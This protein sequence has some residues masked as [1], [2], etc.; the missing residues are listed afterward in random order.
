GSLVEYRY[1]AA[2]QAEYQIEYP[3]YY[4]DVSAMAPT[5]TVSE[6]T[7]ASAVAGLPDRSWTKLTYNAYDARGQMVSSTHYGI[8]TGTGAASTAEGYG[9]TVYAYDQAGQLISR[10]DEGRNAETFAYDGMGRMIASTDLNGGTTSIAFNDAATQTVVTLANGFVQTS[11]YNKAGELVSRTE[12]G[13]YVAGGTSTHKYD[14]LGRVRMTTDAT[15]FNTYH[16]YDKAGR[17]VADINHNGSLTEYRYDA[18][19][20]LIAT[21]R[22]ANGVNSAYFAQLADPNNPIELSSIRPSFH[23]FD[24][25][26]WSFYDKQGRV[27]ATADGSGAVQSLQYDRSG[28][29]VKTVSH[30]NK[31][32]AWQISGFKTDTPLT[33]A[34][35]AADSRDSIARNFYDKE[36]R[37][38]A[39]LDGE[40]FLRRTLYDKAGQAVEEIAYLNATNAAYRASGTLN[41]LIATQPSDANDRRTRYVYDGRGFLRFQVD[42]LNQVTEYKGDTAGQVTSTIRYAGSIA[43]TSDY[44]YDNIRNLVAA[45]GLASSAATRRSWA[46]YDSAGRL[47]F[48]INPEDAVTR[49][50]YDNMGQVTKTVEYAAKRT[51]TTS[52]PSLATMNAWAGSNDGNAAN[53]ITRNYYTARG[54][55]RFTVDAEGYVSRTD[56][57]AEGR[58]TRELRWDTPL[59]GVHDGWTIDTVYT[60]TTG[61]FSDTRYGYSFGGQ[62]T[63][64]WN[65]ENNWTRYDYYGTGQLAYRTVVESD[66]SSTYYHYDGAGRVI[67]EYAAQGTAEQA[68]TLYSYDGHGNLVSVTDPRGN[69]TTRSY[70]KLGQMLTETTA[71]GTVSYQYNAFGEAVKA[72][73]ARGHSS[74]SYYDRLGRLTAH[75]DAE[76][77][78]TER[79]YNVFGDLT[80]TTRRYNRA[81]NAAS[82]AAAPTYAAH[83]QDATTTFEYDRLGR[84]TKT[85]DAMGFYEQYTLDAHGNRVSVRNKIGGVV[86]NAFDRRGLLVAETLPMASH[87]NL[88]NVVAWSV[89]NRF[90]YDARGNRTKKI[91]ADGLAEKRTTTYVYD[92]AD[93]LVETRGDSVA[94]LS[95]SDHSS[96]SSVVPTEKHKYD[97]RGR[98]IETTG[99]LGGRTLYYYDK[100]NRKTV[101]IAANGA[102]TAY[103]YDKNGNVL[104]R[105]TYGTAAALPGTAGGS[106]PAAPGGEYRETS[107]TY[108]ALN[109]L[110]TTTVAN[111]RTGAWNGSNYATAIGSVTTSFDYDANGNLIKT[112]DGNGGTTFS[113][114]DRANRRIASVDAENYLSFWTLDGEGNATQEERYATRLGFAVSTGHDAAWLRS[115]VAGNSADRIT[116]FGYDKNGR[117]TSEWRL[118]IWS[119]NVG[120]TGALGTDGVHGGIQYNYNGLGQVWQKTF[121][122]GDYISFT[123]DSMGRLTQESRSPF[124]D[125]AGASVR[126]TTFYYYNGVNNLTLSRQ[127]GA[128]QGG[129]DRLTRYTYGAGGRMT[130]MTDAAGN[131]YNYFR[132]AAGNVLRES[133]NRTKSDGSSVTEG[134]LYNRDIFGRATSQALA[135]WNGSWAKGDRQDTEY[136][137][138]G[139]ISRRGVNGGWQEQFAYDGAGRMW[140]SNSG[141]GVWRFF[142][143]DANGNQTLA[144]ES[145]GLNLANYTLDQALS[146]A[147]AG[148]A[149]HVGGAYIDGI[150]ATINVFDK[151]GQAV[152]T[153]MPQRQLN[154]TSAA[155]G[156][157]VSRTYTAFG[158]VASETDAR[159]YTTDYL[160][161]TMGRLIEKRSPAVNYTTETGA[162]GSARPTEYYY[163]DRAGRLIGSRDAN[164]NLTTR[165][166]LAGTGHDGS[167]A[168]LTYEY[169]S[170]GGFLR[171]DYDVFGDKRVSWDEISRRTDMSYDAMGRLVQ[172]TRANGLIDYYAYDL[173]GQRTQHWNN[174]LQTPVYGAP[175]QVWVEDP[176]YWDPYYGYVYPGTGHW[177]THTPIVGYAPDKELTDY[178]LQGRVVRQVA[179]GGD[180]TT[181]SYAWNG[182]IAT[183]GMG[184]F[185]GWT[186]TTTMAN[187]RS[188]TEQSDLFGRQVY[189]SDLGS[190]VYTF[191]YNLA[192]RLTQRSG[193]ETVTY[194]WLNSGKVA[195]AFSMTGSYGGD[196]TRKGTTYGYDASGNLTSERFTEEGQQTTYWWNPYDYAYEQNVNSWSRTYK[197]ATAS[198]DG[199]NRIV[200]WAEVGGANMA[201]ANSAYEYDLVGNI[202]RSNSTYKALDH[203]GAQAAYSYAQDNWYRYDSMN[204]L[205]TKGSLSGGQIVRSYGGVDYLYDKAGQRVSSSRTT[206]AQAYVYNPYYDP[207]DYYYGGYG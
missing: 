173:L 7:L 60:Y 94:V 129:G 11:T 22:Y 189:K 165:A 97:Q 67:A 175:E 52:L 185:G 147:T 138:Y 163:Y 131:T 54:E 110:K 91:E 86:T 16:L 140:R 46:V 25:C 108:D 152:Q 207:Y 146:A 194:T 154:D 123:Y 98:L 127:G 197:N 74:Y 177:E 82:V 196:Y 53:R 142:V 37:L 149:Y 133:Y 190:H 167:E 71:A 136:N 164:G 89:T 33:L 3:E 159:G 117:R 176:P 106:A 103:T 121:G 113:F 161:N 27:I 61:T 102:Y 63:D 160:Y 20:R 119:N 201:S 83:A 17:Q 128:T 145:E 15:G 90:E 120:S 171:N 101:E 179:F 8:A 80:G 12:S 193:G 130:A 10:M 158:E 192:G 70:D 166:L 30:F 95:Q 19:N 6:A 199:L 39:V 134:L 203:Q 93:R 186:E 47:A 191:S 92:K 187:G 72:T 42:G 9:R 49:F 137:V 172:Q 55:L 29:L 135:T 56:F 118:Y 122:N 100:L 5:A 69:V 139:D 200:S 73:N 170:D 182:A 76:D 141:D 78:V 184:T 183:T 169:H 23:A 41:Q 34:L 150:N 21:M 64:V 144:I 181:T 45:S 59:A 143:H 57:D 126:P 116:Q 84:I 151:R 205:V 155:T 38:L 132:D 124:T 85:T 24:V 157:N 28:R 178:D 99:A 66:P 50:T 96:S 156:F 14:K 180:V 36:G 162:V 77:Y 43:A 112:T 1:T 107:Y 4:Y 58:T 105:R 188:S 109:R 148:G 104:T 153:R 48:S 88:G 114:Y 198:Y 111:V 195:Q 26:V 174:L 87:D 65:G 75:R 204:R 125:L 79:A 81:N 51:G 44:T 202:R 13:S 168:L 68:V 115:T 32:A 35:P 206:Q 18:N 31:L 40:G 2:G 62:L